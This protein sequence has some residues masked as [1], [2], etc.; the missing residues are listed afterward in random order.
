MRARARYGRIIAA[1]G[2][3]IVAGAALLP[4]AASAAPGDKFKIEKNGNIVANGAAVKVKFSYSCPAGWE[5]GAGVTLVEALGDGF[6]SGYG[7]KTIK[8]TGKKEDATFFIQANTYEG[9]RPFKKGEASV[10][11]NLDAW[12]PQGQCGE[13]MPCPM[14]AE[15]AP[16][17]GG[18]KMSA[19]ADI[20]PAPSNMHREFT[21]VINLQP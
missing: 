14:P 3:A 5:G 18:G 2:A 10:V 16:A 12:N 1:G 9:S 6:A 13:G 20:M 17:A 7:G 8:C 15:P 11:A 21:G 19:P 4:A